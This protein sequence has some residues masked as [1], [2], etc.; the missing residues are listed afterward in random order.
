M[1]AAAGRLI[2]GTIS[3]RG[4]PACGLGLLPQ[5]AP[6][7]VMLPLQAKLH[8]RHNA[9]AQDG[10]AITCHL[11]HADSP[12]AVRAGCRLPP[13]ISLPTVRAGGAGAAVSHRSSRR[14]RGSPSIGRSSHWRIRQA[15]QVC[16]GVPRLLVISTSWGL[17]PCWSFAAQV[18]T[19]AA[20]LAPPAAPRSCGACWRAAR[21][22][23]ARAA[24]LSASARHR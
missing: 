17:L 12:F 3:K 7:A 10:P 13:S 9:W 15:L 5:R 22:P 11:G 20:I 8:H 1:F 24:C 16:W 19:S 6:P 21:W 4:R 23:P 2:P 18:Q 14:R